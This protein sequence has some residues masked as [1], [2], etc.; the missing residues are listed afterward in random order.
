M[1]KIF[2]KIVAII[3]ASLV[4]LSAPTSAFGFDGLSDQLQED[5]RKGIRYLNREINCAVGVSIGRGESVTIIG[6]SITVGATAAIKQN[7]PEAK[8]YAATSKQFGGTNSSNPSGIDIVKDPE[9][10]LRDYIVIALGTNGDVSSSQIAEMISALGSKQILFVNNYHYGDADSYASNNEGFA[11][12]ASKRPT[13]SVIDWA[14]AAHAD[15]EKYID[16][17]D[18]LGV[19]PTAEGKTLFASEI[20]YGLKS[21]ITTVESSVGVSTTTNVSGS[22]VVSESGQYYQAAFDFLKDS[23]LAKNIFIKLKSYGLDDLHVAAIVGNWYVEGMNPVYT[24]TYPCLG[25]LCGG[26]GLAQW[27]GGRPI[28][29]SPADG[30]GRD[31]GLYRY[32]ISKGE[33]GMS[34]SWETQVEYAWAEMTNKGPATGYATV[35]YNHETFLSKTT[36]DDAAEYFRAAYERGVGVE[37]R[38]NAAQAAYKLFAGLGGSLCGN[39]I[40]G[41]GDIVAAALKLS[42]GEYA[43]GCYLWG[44]GHGSYEDLLSRIESKFQ[45]L[46]SKGVDCSGFVSAAVSYAA[47]RHVIAQTSLTSAGSDWQRILIPE[48]GALSVSSTHVEIITKVELGKI[49]ETVGSHT[50]GCGPGKGPSISS[51]PYDQGYYFKYTGGISKWQLGGQNERGQD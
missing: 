14:T 31:G 6:D 11:D 13:V 9:T 5:L 17:S 1:R 48:P 38:Q 23:E 43:S 40:A 34:A 4:L 41:N 22:V 46:Y 3:S 24:P 27:G 19:H 26:Y 2:P 18:G 47:G 21:A 29:S 15:Y 49:T 45:P 33:P 28:G 42:S 7:L 35:Q 39:S 50:T 51:W 32:A 30:A 20:L 25:T 37:K 12:A 44:G 8:F 36:I 16:N 10:E